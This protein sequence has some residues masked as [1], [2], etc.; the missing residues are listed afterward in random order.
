MKKLSIVISISDV[1]IT[2]KLEGSL[3]MYFLNMDD[4]GGNG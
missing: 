4:I 3:G 1:K 2:L